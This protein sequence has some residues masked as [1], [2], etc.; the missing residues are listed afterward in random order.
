MYDA[1]EI[2]PNFTGN[3]LHIQMK[4]L[5]LLKKNIFLVVWTI[6]VALLLFVPAAKAFVLRGLIQVGFF[7]ASTGK[8]N[9]PGN[10]PSFSFINRNGQTLTTGDLKGKV[11]FINFWASW[12]P[13][14]IAEMPSINSLYNKLKDNPRVLFVC[15][16]ADSD[17]SGSIPFMEKHHYDLPVYNMLNS[18]PP[19][20]FSGTLPTTIIINPNGNIVQK[21]EGIANYDTIEM[22]NFLRSLE[23][24]GHKE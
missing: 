1:V 20:F 15:V 19:S 2:N 21:H 3:I 13:P 18:V 5:Q 11:V 6:L 8:E 9:I 24:T 10:A 22:L 16:D 12:C 7:K 23:L 14:C 17:F 4:F